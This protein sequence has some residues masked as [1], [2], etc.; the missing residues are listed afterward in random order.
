M[1]IKLVFLGS[2]FYWKSGTMMGMLYTEDGHRSDWGKVQGALEAGNGVSIRPA[3]DAELVA[4]Y[5]KLEEL[6]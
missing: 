3:N 1:T 4:A 2:D 6:R 5:K